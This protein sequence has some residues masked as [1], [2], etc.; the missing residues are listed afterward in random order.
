MMDDMSRMVRR[1]TGLLV[2]I[3]G[4]FWP[5]YFGGSFILSFWGSEFRQAH[6]TLIILGSVNSLIYLQAVRADY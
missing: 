5:F 6:L 4:V 3:A 2:I 1:V